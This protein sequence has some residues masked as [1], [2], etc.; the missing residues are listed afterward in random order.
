MNVSSAQ[1]TAKRWFGGL[2]SGDI[3]TAL[4]CLDANVEWINYRIEAG[5]NDLMPWIGTYH[6]VEA[7][8]NSFRIF[9]S[10][11]QVN[12]E[13]LIK[14]VVDG[15]EAAGVIHEVSVVKETGLE[16]EIEF[17]Q[18]LTI[19]EG[20]IVRWKSYTDPSPIL[21]ALGPLAARSIAD[22]AKAKAGTTNPAD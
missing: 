5:Y 7:V 15:D 1:D 22:F 12:K 8:L 4:A 16:F 9:T 3:N 19:R 20:K 14:L 17:I 11:V 18:W 21:R 13:E 10:L 6:G 2:T